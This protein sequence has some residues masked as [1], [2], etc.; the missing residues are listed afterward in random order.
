[1]LISQHEKKNSWNVFV[2]IFC[3][4][5]F[6]MK[7]RLFLHFETII[8]IQLES[9]FTHNFKGISPSW[10]IDLSDKNSNRVARFYT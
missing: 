7:F 5:S 6:A 2:T 3:T 1:M 4:L 10:H 8:T 9:T